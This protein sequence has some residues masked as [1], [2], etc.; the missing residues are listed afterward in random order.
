MS[1]PPRVLIVE[2][3]EKTAA[4]LAM[5][6]RRE[7][8]APV[9]ARDGAEGLAL[10]CDEDFDLVV[11]DLMLPRVDGREICRRLRERSAVPIIMVTARATE[12]D[13]VQSLDLGADDYITKPFSPRELMAR[14]R[15]RLR[16]AEAR[17][18]PPLVRGALHIDPTSRQVRV[19]DV[20]VSLTAA[21]FDLLHCLAASP[22]RVW[23]RQQL[24]VQVF[25]EDTGRF[26]RTIDAHVK[27]L[28]GKIETDRRNPYFV[29]TVFGVGY[30]FS[31]DAS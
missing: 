7:G 29:Q 31:A 4:T 1:S 20:P 12:R 13:C 16:N 23:S 22:G 14:V 25:G 11:L 9:I 30:R 5:Y 2:D 10:A 26:D 17:A 3:E 24:M 18:E 19:G 28:R 27:N 21:E 15:A 8:L 6:M